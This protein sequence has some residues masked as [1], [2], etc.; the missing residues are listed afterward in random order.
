MKNQKYS[1]R[2][3]KQDFPTDEACLDFIFDALHSRKCSCGG[4][5]RSIQGRKQYQC[6]QCRFQIAPTAGTIFH[7]SDTPLTLWFHALFVFSQAKSGF[8]AK[9]LEREIGVTYKCAWR[10]LT[11]IRQSLE[12]GKEKLRGS[13]EMDE[14]Y[15]GGKRKAGADNV[16]LSEVMKKK[17][18]ILGAVERKGNIRAKTSP[19]ARARSLGKFLVENVESKGTL[20]LTDESNRYK[21]SARMYDRKMVKHRRKEYVRGTVHTNTIEGFWGHFKRSVRGTHKVISPK[22]LPF[23]LDGFV[24]HYNNRHNDTARFSAL[25]GAVVRV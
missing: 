15:F 1:I 23:Y 6:S 14:T 19:N 17:T 16:N 3:L 13:V 18:I 20:L 12:Q 25:L 4:T 21:L 24:F 2:N 22:Y 5:Y 11:L 9:Q 7:K 10:M 8:S